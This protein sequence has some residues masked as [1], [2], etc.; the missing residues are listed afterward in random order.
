M[1][2]IETERL[3]LRTWMEADAAAFLAA[4][5]SPLVTRYLP[6]AQPVDERFARTWIE[7]AMEEEDREGFSPWPVIRKSDSRLIGRCG[8]HRLPDGTVEVSWMFEPDAWGAGYATEAA[9]AVI[10]YGESALHLRG[11]Y[12][13]IDPRNGASIAVAYRVGMRFDRLVRAYKRDMLRYVRTLG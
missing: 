6:L 8:L 10:D 2:F 4:F 13:L 12:A 11:V 7:G 5:A 3:I 9:R 1:A